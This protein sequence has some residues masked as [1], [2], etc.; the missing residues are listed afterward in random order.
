[1]VLKVFI[2]RLNEIISTQKVN[3]KSIL[4]LDAFIRTYVFY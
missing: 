3:K 1:M 4:F 2:G